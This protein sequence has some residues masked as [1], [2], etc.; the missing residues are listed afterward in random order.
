M[1]YNFSAADLGN[2]EE[3]Y[4]DYDNLTQYPATPYTTSFTEPAPPYHGHTPTIDQPFAVTESP[5]LTLQTP[6]STYTTPGWSSQ[7]A[8]SPDLPLPGEFSGN[9]YTDADTLYPGESFSNSGVQYSGENVN[10][11]YYTPAY[12]QGSA[13]PSSPSPSPNGFPY[14]SLA[15]DN[16][17]LVPSLIGQQN[18]AVTDAAAATAPE[19]PAGEGSFRCK[20]CHKGHTDTKAQDRHEME[21]HEK[22]PSRENKPGWHR[23][24][25]GRNFCH[26]RKSNYERH[27]ST[28]KEDKKTMATYHCQ[29]G[30]EESD[31]GKHAEHYKKCSEG[32]R[33]V[34]RP[35]HA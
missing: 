30:V 9:D 26:Y 3:E 1:T 32:R 25:C 21:V 8:P 6:A 20:Y 10:L 18:T 11:S 23:C 29:C 22:P 31:E 12:L 13:S 5:T 4:N 2:L 16:F 17:H 14:G 35:R 33:G 27:L 7:W 19:T 28:C 24:K 34:G 15:T